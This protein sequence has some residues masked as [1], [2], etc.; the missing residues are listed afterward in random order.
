MKM[1]IT[2]SR[3]TLYTALGLLA[4][5]S[6]LGL[7]SLG[8]SFTPW[9]ENGSVPLLSWQDWQLAKAERLFESEREILRADVTA[10]TALLNKNP[11]PVAA[12]LLTQR[13]EG[14]T[15][16]GAPILLSARTALMGA[17]QA[18]AS[19]SAG[20]LDRESAIVSLQAAIELLK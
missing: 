11:D 16:S 10:I 18:L 9:T 13:I 14:H 7:A 17:A 6:G 20:A 5:L 1:E 3:S 4:F 19:W 12:Q 2:I 8:K 15:S